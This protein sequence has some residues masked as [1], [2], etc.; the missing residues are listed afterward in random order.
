[1]CNSARSCV[2]FDTI[3]QSFR[4][5]DLEAYGFSLISLKFSNITYVI[6][7]K[8]LN[9]TDY[10]VPRQKFYRE[11]SLRPITIKHIFKRQLHFSY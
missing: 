2:I 9:Q 7:S 3:N 8:K 5:A 1:M 10:I 11:L 4:L 6:D